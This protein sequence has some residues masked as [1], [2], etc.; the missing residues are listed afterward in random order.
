MGAGRWG[1]VGPDEFHAQPPRN[2]L[3]VMD[4]ELV[5]EDFR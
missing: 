5:E 4:D 3:A 1:V 2:L